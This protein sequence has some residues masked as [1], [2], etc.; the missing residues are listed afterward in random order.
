MDDRLK[1]TLAAGILAAAPLA[2]APPVLAAPTPTGLRV[3]VETWN[4]TTVNGEALETVL[5]QPSAVSDAMLAAWGRFRAWYLTQVPATLHGQDF[6]HS[7]D[8]KIPSGITLYARSHDMQAPPTL[9]LAAAPQLTLS[10]ASLNGFSAQFHVPGAGVGVCAT[11]PSALGKYADPCADLSVDIDVT[12]SVNITQT[13]GHLLQLGPVVAS[14][15]N[16]EISDPNFPVEVAQVVSSINAFFGGT[17]YQQVL[18]SLADAQSQNL[19]PQLQAPI[20]SLNAA[21]GQLEQSALTRIN[22]GLAPAG[23]TLGQLAHTTLWE[24]STGSAQMLTVLL[25]PPSAGLTLDPSRQTGQVTGVI[26]F[27]PSVQTPPPSC[28][29]LDSTGRISARAQTGPRPVTSVDSRG[30]PTYG[31]APTQALSVSFTGA[32]LQGRQ[33]AYSLARLALGL[34]NLI[35]LSGG[36]ASAAAR[37]Q[38]PLDLVPDRWTNPVIVG[39]GGAILALGAPAADRLLGNTQALVNA[40]AS[41]AQDRMTL[42]LVA[43]IAPGAAARLNAGTPR[44]LGTISASPIANPIANP[45]GTSATA[46]NTGAVGTFSNNPIANPVSTTAGTPPSM[47]PVAPNWG[48]GSA[49]PASSATSVW[50]RPPVRPLPPPASSTPTPPTAPAVPPGTASAPSSLSPR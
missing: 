22:Q 23:M 19:T 5:N 18:A 38:Q 36:Q 13:A 14:I 48:N 37:L 28:A 42:G 29:G 39:P 11:T 2:G 34:P 3:Y 4:P 16:F 25:A 21:I 40:R 31:A 26:T 50:T 12:F 8:S 43:S 33:C 41:A 7:V 15:S 27:D 24:Q 20:D 17:D 47:K 32:P 35:A 49:P 9:T 10:H 6:L 45:V 44:S 1:R 46:P 30:T